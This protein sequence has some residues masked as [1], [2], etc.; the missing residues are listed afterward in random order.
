MESLYGLG[1][2]WLPFLGQHPE[3]YP[4]GDRVLLSTATIEAVVSMN[5]HGYSDKEELESCS[6]Y[7]C[8]A[9]FNHASDPNCAF[10][11]VC[12]VDN[13]NIPGFASVITLR[14]VMAGEEL[15]ISY[16]KDP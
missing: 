4:V 12:S 14:E 16:S 13:V 2:R 7:T 11:N 5:V 1:S 6:M 8:V 10:A 15:C 9:M 3:Y